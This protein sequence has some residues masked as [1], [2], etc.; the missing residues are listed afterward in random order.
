MV[1]IIGYNPTS[2]N[3]VNE[4]FRHWLTIVI[5]ITVQITKQPIDVIYCAVMMRP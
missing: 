2:T 3:H 4:H 1:K 5:L